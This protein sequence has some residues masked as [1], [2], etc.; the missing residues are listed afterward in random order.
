M[1]LDSSRRR[2]VDSSVTLLVVALQSMYFTL[3]PS[4]KVL[5]FR[6]TNQNLTP[7]TGDTAVYA[8]TTV[9]SDDG[10]SI[11]SLVDDQGL[12]WGGEWRSS[13]YGIIAIGRRHPM[14]ADLTTYW[15][16][17]FDDIDGNYWN[18][19]PT[20]NLSG[21]DVGMTFS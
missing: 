9:G 7:M 10:H 12:W 19:G 13:Q 6:L 4:A 17:V 18:Q 14:V 20:G 16:G 11:S 3:A 21:I 5:V 2:G 8:D 1:A 15:F